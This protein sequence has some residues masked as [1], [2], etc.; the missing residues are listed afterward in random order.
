MTAAPEIPADVMAA[1]R[2]ILSPKADYITTSAAKLL[3]ARA[4]LVER[5]RAADVVRNSGPATQDM[6]STFICDALDRAAD[7]IL[8]GASH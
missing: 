1:A 6:E 8:T 4:I 5:Q 3:I 7:E 2:K